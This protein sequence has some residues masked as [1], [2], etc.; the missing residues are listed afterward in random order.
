MGIAKTIVYR[1]VTVA[2]LFSAIFLLGL[3]ITP[4]IPIDLLP[5]ISPPVL[6]VYT[7]YGGA[8]PEEVEEA[9]TR[10]LESQLG[11]VSNVRKLSSTSSEGTSIISLEFTWGSDLNEA[12]QEVRDNIEFVR[13]R[14]PDGIQG[15]SIFKFSTSMIPIM[16]ITVE[17]NRSS[18]ELRALGEDRIQPLLEQVSGVGMVSVSGGRERAIRVE[19]SQNRLEAYNLTIGQISQMLAAQNVEIGAGNIEEGTKNYLIR[20]SEQF[21]SLDEVANAVISYR[22]SRGATKEVR[23]RDIATITDGYK[24]LENIIVFNDQPGMSVEIQKQS[25]TNT[26]VVAQNVYKKLTELEKILPP[27]IK[28]KVVFDSSKVIQNSLNSVINS[29]VLGA[30]LAMLVLLVF[31]RSWKS[32]IIIG[33]S[34][35]ISL[36][37]TT[38]AMYFAGITVNLMTITGLTLGVGMIVDSS[39]VILE[40]IFRYREK[41]T[42][43]KIAA[44]LGTQEMVTAIVASTLTTVCVFLPVIM[45]KGDLGLVGALFEDLA[46]TVIIALLS[47]LFIAIVLVPVLA[48]SGKLIIYTPIQRPL[49]EGLLKSLDKRIGRFFDN[50]NRNYK[51]L[52]TH[53]LDNKVWVILIMAALFLLSLVLV[54]TIGMDFMASQEEDLIILDI[55]MPT[56]TRL[57]LT[58]EYVH[59]IA[60]LGKEIDS[61]SD[62]FHT[63]GLNSSGLGG[64]NSSFGQVWYIL[65]DFEDRTQNNDEIKQI[66]RSHFDSFPAASFEFTVFG[67]DGGG[68]D[69]I[70]VVIQSEDLDEARRVAYEIKD[71]LK[72]ERPEVTEPKVSLQEGRPQAN[73][74]VD[75]SKAYSMGLNIQAIGREINASIDGQVATRFRA[76]G[77]E[78]DIL[79][80]LADTDRNAIPDLEKI[81]VDNSQ[82][83]RVPISSVA[84]VEKTTGPVSIDRENQIRTIRVTGGILPG[85]STSEVDPLVRSL[86][87]DRIVTDDSVI[88]SYGGD[89]TEIAETLGVFLSIVIIAI[90][91]VYGVMASQF[92]SFKGPFIIFLTIP[93]MMIGITGIYKLTG[94][95]FSIYSAVGV[96]MLAGIVVNNGI[97]MVDYTNI[98]R[99]RGLEL[100]QACIEAGG[101]RLR[102]V[103]MTSLTTIL[104]MFPVAFASGQGSETVKHL[105]QTVIGGMT[106]STVL[107]LVLVP[108]LYA[109]FNKEKTKR[110]GA[111]LREMEN[112]NGS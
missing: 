31:L 36:L 46:F 37:V 25:G 21:Q 43:P 45:F 110:G 18:E 65:K 69:P 39:I 108:V 44:I 8:G 6:T 78:L 24:D 76:E 109:L 33:L 12:S 19:V 54:P 53:C 72:A 97:V 91:L 1:P 73:I 30:I 111:S 56:G 16:L 63:S 67:P 11:G 71:L 87:K 98:L 102:P 50:L 68:G 96:V 4:R 105:G 77:E 49:K 80:V 81:F 95:N 60:A 93:L 3:F 2:I 52:L 35:P 23:L 103:L 79:V 26:V 106:A 64:S 38:M 15:P 40:N 75:R 22:V 66:L 74:V 90:G 92:E 48:S 104:G 51:V 112:T 86:I 20:T 101:N 13:A 82:G 14:L 88:I 89:F 84:R 7:I 29:A 57:D 59:Q 27:D 83:Q 9:V 61:V 17:G 94:E 34:I 28:M 107:T 41:G 42:K 70:E 32:T 100:R 47:S 62:V 85:L 55:T 10:V 5:E 58:E 99:S